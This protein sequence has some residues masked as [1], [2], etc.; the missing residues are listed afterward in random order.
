[1]RIAPELRALAQPL[2]RVQHLAEILAEDPPAATLRAGL[3]TAALTEIQ[4]FVTADVGIRPGATREKLAE[5]ILDQRKTSRIK[6]TERAGFQPAMAPGRIKPGSLHLAERG[7]I[8][9]A[10]PPFEVPETVLIRGQH[11]AT[12]GGIGIQGAHFRGL[13]RIGIAPHRLVPDI[14]KRVLGI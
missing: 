4:R 3:A 5:Q 1:M 2:R 13:Q 7:V 11:H 6:R 10:Q 9:M 14:G 8:W 12:R